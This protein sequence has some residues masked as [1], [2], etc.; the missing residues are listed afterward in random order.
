V[1][2]APDQRRM[3]RLRDRD[4]RGVIGSNDHSGKYSRG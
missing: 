2:D 3:V 1:H 4:A